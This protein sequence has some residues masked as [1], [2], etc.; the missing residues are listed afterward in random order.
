MAFI[1]IYETE[2]EWVAGADGTPELKDVKRYLAEVEVSSTDQNGTS[3][4]AIAA[5]MVKRYSRL[6]RNVQSETSS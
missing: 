5:D 6:Y 4:A 1:R 3:A 2:K